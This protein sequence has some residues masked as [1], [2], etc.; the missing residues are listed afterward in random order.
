MKLLPIALTTILLQVPSA[1]IED[2]QKDEARYFAIGFSVVFWENSSL[3]AQTSALIFHAQIGN[4]LLGM[5]FFLPQWLPVRCDHIFRDMFRH[6]K[7]ICFAD[8]FASNRAP[9]D[10]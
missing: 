9:S 10:G 8:T 1:D 4:C 7:F 3:V 5:M 6:V 2:P